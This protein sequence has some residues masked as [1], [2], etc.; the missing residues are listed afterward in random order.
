M[1]SAPTKSRRPKA[2]LPEH[3]EL[4][5]ARL[6]SKPP[7]GPEWLHEI[8]YDGYRLTCRIENGT[9]RLSTRGGFDWTARF[10]ELAADLAN[11]RLK[12]AW[13]DGEGAVF[14]ADGVSDFPALQACFRKRMTHSLIYCVFD[15]LHLNGR[16][17]RSMPLIERKRLL[18]QAVA[19]G[20]NRVRYVDHVQGDGPLFFEHC[21][22]LGL[23]GCVS[24]RL[25]R[26]YR[27]GRGDDWQKTKC[28]QQATFL[29]CGYMSPENRRCGLGALILG[30]L[31][32]D[33]TLHHDGRV[34]TGFSE[35]VETAILDQLASL[36]QEACPFSR[37]P[38]RERGRTT[39]WVRP[40]LVVSVSHLG[41]TGDGL[42]RQVTFRGVG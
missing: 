18:A 23:E 37:R 8:K 34:G 27:P 31:C 32:D 13:L 5:L 36:R 17:L 39:E 9:V 12:S 4:K 30:S 28:W 2:P 7:D 1:R 38:P 6:T 11:L 40:M 26:P 25:D 42:L 41:R 21:E 10:P 3:F 16:D 14:R 29:V 33:G 24:K 35:A 22:R 20:S 19:G 15:A